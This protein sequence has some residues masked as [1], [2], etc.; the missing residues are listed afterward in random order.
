MNKQAN[1]PSKQPGQKSGGGR[2]NAAPAKQD[3]KTGAG[4]KTRK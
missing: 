1:W 2:D 3:Q 4:G